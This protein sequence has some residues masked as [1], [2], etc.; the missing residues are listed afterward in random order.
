MDER[1][2]KAEELAKYRCADF[3][4]EII[5]KYD[6]EVKNEMNENKENK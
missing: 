6:K 1:D 4:L 5:Q 2:L 3:L